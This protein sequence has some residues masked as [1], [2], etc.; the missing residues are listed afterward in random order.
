MLKSLCSQKGNLENER[1]NSMSF[2]ELFLSLLPNYKVPNK[3]NVGKNLDE[4]S[5]T[6][7]KMC[8]ECKGLC[9]QGCGCHFSPEDFKNIS[10]NTLKTEIK[11][12]YIS[13]EWVDGEL[14]YMDGGIYIL[15]AR[16]RGMPIVDCLDERHPCVLWN[17]ETGCKLSYANRPKGGRLLIP[18]RGYIAF[19]DIEEYICQ[20]RYSIEECCKDW[21]KYQRIL[22]RLVKHF[23]NKD[24]P[25]SI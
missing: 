14:V 18:K 22:I 5:T 4:G 25:C 12:G 3:R 7:V 6:N 8:A 20:S 19:S 9:C 1:R 23:R 15:R 13:I 11:K 10:F 24:Y 21:S 2:D 17:E 16:N